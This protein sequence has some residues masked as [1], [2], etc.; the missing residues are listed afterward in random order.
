MLA[1]QELKLG[2]A[3]SRHGEAGPLEAVD[4]DPRRG[5]RIVVLKL[6]IQPHGVGDNRAAWVQLEQRC[7]RRQRRHVGIDRQRH[8]LGRAVISSRA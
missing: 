6:L 2:A 8:A 4:G 7:E 1:G 5:L 3:M